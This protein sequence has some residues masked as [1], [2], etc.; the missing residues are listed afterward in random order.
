MVINRI[1]ILMKSMM[2][3]PGEPEIANRPDRVF[4][5]YQSS[6]NSMEKKIRPIAI[7]IIVI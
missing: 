7:D 2:K 5:G 6:G 1:K 4:A 3:I